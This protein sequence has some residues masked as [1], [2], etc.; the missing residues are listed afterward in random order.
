MAR[1]SGYTIKQA[2]AICERLAHGESLN[3]ICQDKAMPSRSTVIRWLGKHPAFCDLYAQARRFQADFLLDEMLDIA[4]GLPSDAT[5]A[6]I[7]A[8]KLR[9]DA[10]KWFISKVAPKR[11]GDSGT[12]FEDGKTDDTPASIEV[13]IVDASMPEEYPVRV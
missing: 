4:D 3:R 5:Q 1:P 6:Q 12:G 10:R 7:T 9:I 8:A 2:Q 13:K 11:Y